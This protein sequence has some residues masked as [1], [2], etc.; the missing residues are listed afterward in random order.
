MDNNNSDGQSC[1]GDDDKKEEDKRFGG[2]ELLE[3]KAPQ[4]LGSD[5]V[6]QLQFYKMPEF[7]RTYF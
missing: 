2:G 1:A 6:V 7:S 3:N 5:W 4:Y